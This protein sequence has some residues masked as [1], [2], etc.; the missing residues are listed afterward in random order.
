M[1][2]ELLKGRETF[3][4]EIPADENNLS[5]VRDFIADICLRAG[6]S[7]RETNNTKLAMDEACT[8]IIKHAYKYNPD[9]IIE[10]R[11]SRQEDNSI[12]KFV[13][14]IFDS[15]ISFD[16]SRYTAPDMTE[17]F[18]KLRHGGLGILLMKKLMDEVEYGHMGGERNTIRLVKYLPA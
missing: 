10:I 18:K 11:I 3:H 15:G 12:P 9:G 4:L 5:E 17:Y 6:F 8:N 13:V 1:K 7:K 16:S 2:R 14:E